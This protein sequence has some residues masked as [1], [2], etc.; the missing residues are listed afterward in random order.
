MKFGEPGYNS[1]RQIIKRRRG[2]LGGRKH[3]IWWL[4]GKK[5]AWKWCRVHDPKLLTIDHIVP[6]AR[7]IDLGWKK[8]QINHRDNLQ[9]LCR[10]H[11]D[12][13]DYDIMRVRLSKKEER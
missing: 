4:T 1:R 9:L 10:K 5:C 13:K 6:I 11:H 3:N 7:A 2:G 12:L 8:Y